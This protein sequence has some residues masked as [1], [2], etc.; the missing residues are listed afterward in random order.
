VG[1]KPILTYD[2]MIGLLNSRASDQVPGSDCNTPS[3]V[4]D[5]TITPMQ[6]YASPPQFFY[7]LKWVDTPR[8]RFMKISGVLVFP[9]FKLHS[10]LAKFHG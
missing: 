8:P 7:S 9:L 3:P 2:A 10:F 4:V 6:T 5:P 1:S